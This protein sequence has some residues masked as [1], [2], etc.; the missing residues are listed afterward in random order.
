[1]YSIVIYLYACLC[2]RLSMHLSVDGHLGYFRCGAM[3]KKAV[4]NTY[5]Q[6]FVYPCVFISYM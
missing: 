2:Q 4:I 3:T 6:I 1:M 5:G